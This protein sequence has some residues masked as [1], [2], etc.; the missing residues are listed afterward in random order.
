M[1]SAVRVEAHAKL[2]LFLRVLA[3][4][5]DGFHGVETLFCLVDLADQLVAER[6]EGHEITIE[7]E[8]AEVGPAAENL[9]LRGAAAVLGAVRERFGV[10]LTLTKRIPPRW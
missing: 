8:G 6:R 2:N 7:V 4:E 5:E 10:H 1:T 3:R 9:A